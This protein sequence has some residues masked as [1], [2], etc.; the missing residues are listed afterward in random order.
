MSALQ[1]WSLQHYVTSDLNLA[2]SG[3]R[4]SLLQVRLSEGDEHA[5]GWL[6]HVL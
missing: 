2:H 6:H 1:R 4:E 3:G 5:K